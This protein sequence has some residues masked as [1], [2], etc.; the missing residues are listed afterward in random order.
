MDLVPDN[1]IANINNISK[2]F[3]TETTKV[4]DESPIAYLMQGYKDTVYSSI[5]TSFGL[6][7]LLFKDR[8][9]GEVDTIQTVGDETVKDYASKKNQDDNDNRGQY[10]STSYHTHKNYIDKNRE[11]TKDHKSGNL[12]DGYTGKRIAPNKPGDLDHVISAKSTHDDPR[13]VL[14][15]VS[16][17]D[18]ANM[19]DNLLKTHRSI[20]RSK[21]KKDPEEYANQLDSNR[22]QRTQNIKN[23]QDKEKRGNFT[24]KDRNELEKL[25]QLNSVDTDI[26]R[27]K[28]KEVKKDQT[29]LYESKYYRSKK[30]HSATAIAATKSGFK[31]GIREATGLILMDTWTVIEEEMP[32]M[33]E[34]LRDDFT[35]EKFFVSLKELFISAYNRVYDNWKSYIQ[36]FKQ[37]IL[38]GALASL[39]STTINIFE[40]TFSTVGRILRQSWAS[41]IEAVKILVFNPDKLPYGEVLKSIFKIIATT[42]SVIAGALL[43]EVISNHI[44]VLPPSLQKA[45]PAFAGSLLAGV[46]SVSLLYFFDY[47][48]KVQEFVDFANQIIDDFN[49]KLDYY[50]K[51]T[52]KLTEFIAQ[53][54][55]IDY[56]TLEK[57]VTQVSSLFEE[58]SKAKNIQEENEIFR[59]R[60]KEYGIEMPYNSKEE[61]EN[62]MTNKSAVLKI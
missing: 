21:G 22:D 38:A 50:T 40:T 13:R 28:A 48:K 5:I 56:K 51:V 32:A 12:I 47:S 4:S 7:M 15:G 41:I 20:N 36:S 14:A 30:F 1:Y 19:P 45:V 3:K 49:V 54:E 58:L 44:Q 55:Q 24:D 61:R 46:L 25:E 34:D 17:Q 52:Q 43:Q 11:Y 8:R 57:E 42:A 27:S 26:M 10:D 59:K 39:T 37:G 33:A 6:D 23:L 9:G 35:L 29:E 53:M 2:D 62:F 16:G 18:A 60:L 31:M